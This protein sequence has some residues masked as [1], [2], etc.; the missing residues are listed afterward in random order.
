[1]EGNLRRCLARRCCRNAACPSKC[2][3]WHLGHARLT[4]CPSARRYSSVERA[5]LPSEDALGAKG[6]VDDEGDD[7]EGGGASAASASSGAMAADSAR[8]GSCC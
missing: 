1:M 5:A 3:R 4:S 2:P 8:L 7:D 6:G